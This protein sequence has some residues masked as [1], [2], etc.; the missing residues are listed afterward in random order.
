MQSETLECL[1]RCYSDAPY[2]GSMPVMTFA[3][4]TPTEKLQDH[5]VTFNVYLTCLNKIFHYVIETTFL[6][7]LCVKV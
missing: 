7:Y 2:N 4:F 5:D 3:A 6:S 1:V